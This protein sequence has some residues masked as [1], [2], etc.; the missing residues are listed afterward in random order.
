M[1]ACHFNIVPYGLLYVMFL[2]IDSKKQKE[3]ATL[4][5]K[6]LIPLLVCSMCFQQEL[7][8]PEFSL[9]CVATDNV[10]A[11]RFCND[12]TNVPLAVCHKAC[13][14]MRQWIMK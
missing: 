11:L 8:T 9:S 12:V 2:Y 7:R 14:V 13:N 6:T 1:E 5:D 10:T 4:F 3:R